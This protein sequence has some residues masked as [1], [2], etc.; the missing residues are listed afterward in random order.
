MVV[1]WNL[2]LGQLL[3]SHQNRLQAD[4]LSK[5]AIVLAFLQIFGVAR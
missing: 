1:P 3:V 4:V 5:P 2:W